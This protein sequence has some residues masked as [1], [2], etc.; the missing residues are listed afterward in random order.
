MIISPELQQLVHGQD[1]ENVPDS[2]HALSEALLTRHSDAIQAI[3]FYGSC[4][5]SDSDIE[6]IVDLYL[7]VDSYRAMYD[8]TFLAVANK[9]LP[10]NV[11]YIEVPF[12]DRKVRAKYAILS[13]TDFQRSTSMKWFHSYFWARFAQPTKVLYAATPQ[14]EQKIY[15]ALAQAIMTFLTRTL[16]QIPPSFD[17]LTLWKTGLSLTYRAE[18]R[19]EKPGR[20]KQ[21][22]EANRDYYQQTADAALPQLSP[23]ITVDLS[24]QPPCFQ[25]HYSSAIHQLNTVTWLLRR[26]QGKVLSVLRLIKGLF[27]FQGGVDYILWKIERHSG[28]SIEL[29]PHQRKHPLLASPVVF[30][31][32]YRKGA[33][34]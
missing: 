16:P 20:I 10:P 3:L 24:V 7:I 4:L 31:K 17:A 30:W 18:L 5:R 6:G 23:Q 27:T 25:A 29:T 21:I 15:T 26:G 13:L 28:V 11:F 8:T 22:V 34:R 1:A 33:F 12:Q 14:V 9:L 32:L 19:T 2:I